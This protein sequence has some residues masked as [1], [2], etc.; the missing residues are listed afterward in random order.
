MIRGTENRRLLRTVQ[1][2]A[3][4]VHV[5]TFGLMLYGVEPVATFYYSFA[6]WTYILFLSSVNQLKRGNSLLFGSPREF[7]F[8]F[9]LSTPAWLIFELYNFRLENWHY[10]GI[11]AETFIRWPGYFIAYGT[12]LPGL[13][14]TEVF[15]R[16]FLISGPVRGR[17]IRVGRGVPARLALTGS[18][19][20]LAPLLQ[21][22]LFFPLVWL[23]GIFLLDPLLYRFGSSRDSL[24]RRAETGDYTLPLRL[25]AAGMIC[26]LLWEFWNF[27]AAAK[28]VY[29]I[30]FV[31]FLKVF[32]MPLLGFL[33]FPPFALECYLIYRAALLLRGASFP[34][35]RFV[36]GGAITL[37]V[38]LSGLVLAGID[39]WTIHSYRQ[40]PGI[41]F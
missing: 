18:L 26:G 33:G 38:V 34:H 21:P 15:V 31:D 39:R 17:S 9:L 2:S 27:W 19:M 20:M 40:L 5:L 8:I 12:V 36:V 23:G 28:W 13:F 14:E 24:L 35:R 11:P 30:P 7:C 16:N 10:V 32:E 25:L 3:A 22:R 1:L 37:T 29:D 4:A 41:G 6:W